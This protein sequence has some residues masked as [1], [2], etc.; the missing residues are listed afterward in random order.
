MKLSRQRRFNM[1]LLEKGNY[2]RRSVA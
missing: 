1:N 2:T